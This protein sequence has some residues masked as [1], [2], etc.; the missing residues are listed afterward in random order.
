MSHPTAWR[1][2]VYRVVYPESARPTLVLPE[3]EFPV[4]DCSE[5]GLR[6]ALTAGAPAL[7]YAAGD[8]IRG[9]LRFRRGV[10]RPISGEVVRV[11]DRTLAIW[12][13][14]DG[15]PFGEIEAE[16]RYLDRESG[17]G[18]TEFPALP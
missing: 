7:P 1:R 12:F 5:L 2:A 10:A 14:G 8:V 3:G 18:N 9:E 15:V 13:R 4:I 11:Q 17:P 6:L 16:K